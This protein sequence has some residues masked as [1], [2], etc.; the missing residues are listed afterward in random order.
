MRT[1]IQKVHNSKREAEVVQALSSTV[2][3]TLKTMS[4]FTTSST[5]INIGDVSTLDHNAEDVSSLLHLTSI[6]IR[7][8]WGCIW[9][10]STLAHNTEDHIRVH[11]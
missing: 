5:S 4:E 9:E 8:E 10:T 6:E 2:T 1:P 7:E 11:D 3:T